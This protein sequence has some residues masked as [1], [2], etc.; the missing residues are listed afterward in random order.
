MSTSISYTTHA[1]ANKD[2]P[3]SSFEGTTSTSCF[4]VVKNFF[5][6]DAQDECGDLLYP[7]F[8]TR[9][10]GNA[11]FQTA[12][13]ASH[14]TPKGETIFEKVKDIFWHVNFKEEALNTRT[15]FQSFCYETATC[16]SFIPKAA[17]CIFLSL[18]QRQ[19]KMALKAS[20]YLVLALATAP[21]YIALKL[22]F[23]LLETL[24][25]YRTLFLLA[26][27]HVLPHVLIGGLLG[28]V[29]S[30]SMGVVIA[31]TLL[32]YKAVQKHHEIKEAELCLDQPYDQT[33]LP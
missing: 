33:Q 6:P 20:G 25:R 9:C 8:H 7:D 26:A 12:W 30:I 16:I 17:V 32:I 29:I 15:D 31:S 27:L 21:L 11:S 5:N 3:S 22:T 24:W 10:D 19:P 4:Q 2:I 14:L 23:F 13:K 1:Y 18:T 28:T